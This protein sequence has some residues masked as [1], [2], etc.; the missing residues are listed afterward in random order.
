MK[1]SKKSLEICVNQFDQ[2]YFKYVKTNKF[3]I[4]DRIKVFLSNS[5]SYERFLKSSAILIASGLF[6]FILQF[7]FNIEGVSDGYINTSAILIALGFLI[8]P[9]LDVDKKQKIALKL[10][11]YSMIFSIASIGGLRYLSIAVFKEVAF[12]KHLLGAIFIVTFFKFILDFILLIKRVIDRFF[13]LINQSEKKI[14]KAMAT[15]SSIV[16]FMGS[17]IVLSLTI[18]KEFLK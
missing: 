13:V 16:T 15:L 17:I 12:Y 7:F 3:F 2:Y 5:L 4:K 8:F 9:A 6:L 14:S 18:Y 11:F 1:H 10:V